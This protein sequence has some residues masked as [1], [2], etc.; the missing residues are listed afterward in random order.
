MALYSEN[1][2]RHINTLCGENAELFTVK[3]SG[4][5]VTTENRNYHHLERQQME[6]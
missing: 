5:T 6:R 1:H 2:P 3:E 4:H